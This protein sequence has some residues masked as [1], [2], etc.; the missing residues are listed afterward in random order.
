MTTR[1]MHGFTLIEL[2]MV[3][4]IIAIIAAIAIPS[5]LRARQSANEASAIG[6]LRS[7]ASSQQNF[8]ASAARGGYA[9]TLPRL[10]TAC[11]GSTVPFLSSELTSN[12]TVRKSGFEME[13]QPASG[14]NIAPTDCNGLATTS[15]FYMTA[16]AADPGIT[17]NRAF[18]VTNFGSIWE[19]VTAP[20]NIAPTE[21]EMLGPA[22]DA[23]HPLR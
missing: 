11:P 8:A 14:A 12:V 23:V 5:L 13:M 18:A 2:L 21:A 20:G 4:A 3:V 7:V 15:G 6:S 22:N 17:A 10:G 1:R 19:N 9:P 16:T